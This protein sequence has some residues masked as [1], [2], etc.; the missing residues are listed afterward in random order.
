MFIFIV[1]LLIA[2]TTLMIL[3][4]P[5]NQV[6]ATF[7]SSISAGCV[8]GLLFLI[9]QNLK[10]KDAKKLDWQL[11]NHSKRIIALMKINSAFRKHQIALIN[12]QGDEYKYHLAEAVK[13]AKQF[14]KEFSLLAI[15]CPNYYKNLTYKARNITEKFDDIMEKV[16]WLESKLD[17]PPP[18]IQDR[19]DLVVAHSIHCAFFDVTAKMHDSVKD[20]IE[21]RDEIDKSIV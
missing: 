12:A 9:Y 18:Q 13:Y 5:C 2:S 8:T 19:A 11:E 20:I 3:L 6:W 15:T 4:Y 7:F 21:K 10:D 17:D 1:A 14:I 16:S